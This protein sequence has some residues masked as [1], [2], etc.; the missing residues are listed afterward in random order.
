MNLIKSLSDKLEEYSKCFFQQGN[1]RL[2]FE[3]LNKYSD[4]LADYLAGEIEEDGIV[5]IATHNCLPFV[6]AYLAT[7]KSERIVLPLPSLKLL[8]VY[9]SYLHFFKS[10]LIITHETEFAKN[11]SLPGCKFLDINSQEFSDNLYKDRK[12][13]Y[14]SKG[15]NDTI[16]LLTTGGTTGTPKLVELTNCN[17]LS[18]LLQIEEVIKG[19]DLG[20][21]IL[22]IL[23][24]FHAFGLLAGIHFP[25][26]FGK[27]TYIKE[28][29]QIKDF[30]DTIISANIEICFFV[31]Q[32]ISIFNKALA[33]KKLNL[34]LRFCVSGAD[35]LSKE[36]FERFKEI[37]SI[38]VIEGYG[39]TEASPVTHLNPLDNPK[40]ESIGKPLPNTLCK[41]VNGQLLIKGPQIM[42][43]YFKNEEETQSIF[44]G[45]YLKTGDIAEVDSQGYYYIKG[46]MKEVIKCAGE[47]IF[48][49][50]IERIISEL[51]EVQDVAVIGQKNRKHGQVPVA[52]IVKKQ[53][54]AID[55]KYIIDYTAKKLP[56]N[57][58]PRKVIFMDSLPKTLLGKVKKFMLEEYLSKFCKF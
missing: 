42:K 47:S 33:D 46:R 38:N 5:I 8:S 49:Y 20:N 39:L 48:P 26:F 56:H 44:F 12:C 55:E 37:T 34:P 54:T 29:F 13:P 10:I 18:N 14:F 3:Q 58:I 17:L 45:E 35:H 6:V 15:K 16:V 7:L 36:E 57:H 22:T 25:I 52:F 11:F 53:D 31:P 4:S 41:I 32:V 51:E 23:P 40:V 43:G 21:N 30:I 28:Q 27:N 19:K 50:E 1:T 24:F 2:T 9:E